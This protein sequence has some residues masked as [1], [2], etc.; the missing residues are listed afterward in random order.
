MV[1]Q[2]NGAMQDMAEL[3]WLVQI[4][5]DINAK[6][7]LEI[8]TCSGGTAAA[9]ASVGAHVVTMDIVD[10]KKQKPNFTYPWE[11]EEYKK[12]FPDAKVTFK[13]ADSR[14]FYTAPQVRDDYDLVLIDGDH[15]NFSGYTDFKHYGKMGKVVAVHDINQYHDPRFKN[16]DWFP[17]TFWRLITENKGFKTKEFISPTNTKGAAGIGVVYMKPGDYE[18][19]VKMYER[20]LLT[21]L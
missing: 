15:S 16:Q 9:L 1:R 2:W 7:I 5:H 6:K 3:N 14:P 17:R 10:Y 11:S 19:L 12:E 4:A 20:Y 8:G 18:K 21:T 13:C